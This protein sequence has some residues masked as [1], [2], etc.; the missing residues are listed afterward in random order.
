MAESVRHRPPCRFWSRRACRSEYAP[1]VRY[2]DRSDAAIRLAAAIV[3]ADVFERD[4]WPLVLGVPRGGIP[5]AAMVRDRIGGDLDVLVT[6]KVGAPGNP[7]YAIGAVTED[8][9]ALIDQALVD[10]I[11]IDESYVHEETQRQRL[12]VARRAALVRGSVERMPIS[13][14]VCVIVDD[15][16][17][18]GAT[19]EASLRL[20]G[21]AGAERIIAAVPVG[22]PATVVR[23]RAVS[24]AVVCPLQPEPFFAVGT[25]Y[26][27]FSQVSEASVIE[28]LELSRASSEGSQT[29]RDSTATE[30]PGHEHTPDGVS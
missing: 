13:G 11:G 25:W 8:G 24:D 2:R 23:L 3:E 18:T 12:E 15:G 9:T 17:A 6:R 20:V 21:R 26:V 27:D 1:N 10:R 4:V 14:R 16:V 19:L 30:R 22:P 7:E 28:A 5:I 29:L